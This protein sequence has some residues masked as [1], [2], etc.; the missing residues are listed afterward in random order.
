[1]R[2]K[3]PG[4]LKARSLCACDLLEHM[5]RHTGDRPLVCGRCGKT[6]VARRYLTRH[7]RTHTRERPF[8]CPRCGREFGDRSNHAR[9]LA[10]VHGGEGRK[11]GKAS[12]I[13]IMANLP[14][15]TQDFLTDLAP[16]M[17]NTFQ[18]HWI[19]S[20]VTIHNNNIFFKFV[21]KNLYQVTEQ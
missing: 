15:P 11:R 13:A 5:R 20:E 21:L 12:S 6:F 4:H 8:T 3:N 2:K 9:H 1:M 18:F 16:G 19:D 10:S 14:P 17:P 7:A